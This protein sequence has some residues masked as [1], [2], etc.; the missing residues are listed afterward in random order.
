M[1]EHLVFTAKREQMTLV[2]IGLV[3]VRLD[4]EGAVIELC[5]GVGQKTAN[6]AHVILGSQLAQGMQRVTAVPL[7]YG[8]SLFTV[9]CH[10]SRSEQFRQ[11]DQVG[12][13]RHVAQVALQLL[14]VGFAVTPNDVV[15][16]E[17]DAQIA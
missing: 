2:V 13:V 1:I 11:D 10:K 3:A 15:L 5:R 4:D 16:N 9:C 17:C 8:S 14:D 12:I 7:G 6:D